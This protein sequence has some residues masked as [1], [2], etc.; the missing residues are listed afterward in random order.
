MA[1]NAVKMK[2]WQISEAAE[3]KMPRPE[4]WREK[5]QLERDELIPYGRLARMDFMKIMDRLKAKPDGK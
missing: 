1:Y 5:L 2:D 4:E 3:K